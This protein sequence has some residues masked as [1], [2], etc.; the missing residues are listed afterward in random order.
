MERSVWRLGAVLLF[1]VFLLHCHRDSSKELV[2]LDFESDSEL[3]RLDWKCHA[4]YS[5]SHE[6]STHGLKSLKMELYPSDYPGV[7]PLLREHDWSRYKAFCFDI[8]NPQKTAVTIT[9]RLDDDKKYPNYGDRCNKK[10][11]LQS[12]VN[13][14]VIPLSSFITSGSR[15][16]LNLKSI[17]RFFIFLPHPHERIVLFL[18]YIR[19]SRNY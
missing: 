8:Y 10:V 15:R 6:H 11:V 19:L 1:T 4:L 14:V 5:L 16:Q 17:W 3:D 12:G 2:L 13:R 9:V 7:A 18:D